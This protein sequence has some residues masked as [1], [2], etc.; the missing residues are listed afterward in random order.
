MA[1][2]AGAW[3]LVERQREFDAIRAALRPERGIGCGVLLTGAAGVG[4]TTLA[5][6]V[7]DSVDGQV[8]WV[9]GTESARSIPLGAFGHLISPG[10]LRDPVL[11]LSAARDALLADGPL[12]L[13]IDDAHLLDQLSATLL[14]QL[15]IDHTARIIATVRSGETVPDAVTSLWKDG[16]LTRLD[17]VPFTKKQSI[18]LVE[19]ALGGH[20]EGLSADLMW[21]TS[22]GNALFLRH[23]VEGALDAG[24]LRKVRGVWQLRGRAT[25]T[26]ELAVLLEGRIE[27]LPVNVIDALKLLSLCEPIDLDVLSELAGV[28]AVEEAETRGLI[29]VSQDRDRINARFTHPIFGEVI[30]RRLGLAT[31]RRLRGQ[32]VTVMRAR[33]TGHESDRIRLADLALDSDQPIDVALLIDAAHAAVALSDVALGERF[34]RAAVGRGGGLESADPLARALLWQGR[35]TEVEE[36]MTEFDPNQLDDRSLLRWGSTRIANLYFSVG[37]AEEGDPV[38]AVLKSRITDPALVLVVEGLESLSAF[39]QNRLDDALAIGQR[40]L[41]APAARPWAIAWAVVAVSLSLGPIGRG[42]DIDVIAGRLELVKSRVDGLL[43]HL[44]EFGEIQAL[45]FT[46]RFA[47][48][49]KKAAEFRGFST[50]GQYLAWGMASTMIGW[51]ESAQGKFGHAVDTLEASVAALLSDFAPAWTYPA[52]IALC[53]AY[54]ALGRATDAE[55][56]IAAARDRLGQ[57]KAVFQPQIQMAEAWVAAAEG[58]PVRAIELA[59]VAAHAAAQSH[60]FAVE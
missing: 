52:R 29:Q 51:V 5:R 2:M 23:L 49:E 33:G 30:R 25:I 40:V 9:A 39:H 10:T 41:A 13:G 43:V 3:P 59:H 42:N 26:N 21:E 20:L 38:L 27:R 22:G 1:G 4:K 50:S 32:L 57:H 46:G 48:A 58:T 45:T 12:V 28:D 55:S 34:A 7:I 8:R 11:V 53:N 37:N 56:V 15:A 47:D 6:G 18:K 16:Y 44:A 36:V 35:A 60:Q 14:H 31:S 54:A 19:T 17:L 24:R